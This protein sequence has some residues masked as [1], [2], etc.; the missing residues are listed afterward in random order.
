ML[1]EGSIN[2][3]RDLHP[4][5]NTH[6]FVS[7]ASHVP[8]SEMILQEFCLFVHVA[9]YL[10]LCALDR[11]LRCSSH[12]RLI[13]LTFTIKYCQGALT[14]LWV[15]ALF[16]FNIMLDCTNGHRVFPPPIIHTLACGFITPSI[17][18]RA[19]F[20]YPMFG[21]TMWPSLDSSKCDAVRDLK[22]T[23]PILDL[24]LSAPY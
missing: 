23:C 1:T 11:T 7:R 13:K 8:F 24:E 12:L 20:L 17:K 15:K 3:T 4:V 18:S 10:G 21:L 9:G 2:K 19:G 16:I 6:S 22:S 5:I 14:C